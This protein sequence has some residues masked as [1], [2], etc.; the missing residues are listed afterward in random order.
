MECGRRNLRHLTPR[1]KEE[2]LDPVK[3]CP[4]LQEMDACSGSPSTLCV[5]PDT[6]RPSPVPDSPTESTSR[7]LGDMGKNCVTMSASSHLL[8]G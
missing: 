2:D 6:Q 3:L 1:T 7:S 8:R 5:S 4:P